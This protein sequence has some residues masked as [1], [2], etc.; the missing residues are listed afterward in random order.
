M[1]KDNDTESKGK[2]K[3]IIIAVAI[4]ALLGGGAMMFLGGG[5]KQSNS[6]SEGGE[7][8]KKQV[9][10]YFSLEKPLVANF[11]VQSND[12]VRYIQIKLKVMARD[13]SIINA[14]KLHLPAIKHEILLLL[15]SQKYDVLLKTVGVKAMQ[16]NV[17]TL[18]NK[19][20]KKENQ[21]HGLEAVYFTSLIMQ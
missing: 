14:F 10:I 15:V 17:L 5:E 12:A 2:L 20:L 7:V 1:A 8:S 18:T 4:L 13:P 3:I 19:I 6:P 9:P 11:S 21:P 16:K